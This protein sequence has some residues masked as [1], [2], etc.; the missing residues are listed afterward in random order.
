MTIP[1]KIEELIA[2]TRAPNGQRGDFLPVAA[3]IGP[4]GL[5]WL[6]EQVRQR[7]AGGDRSA[8]RTEVIREAIETKAVFDRL[9]EISAV[10]MTKMT[11]EMVYEIER[12]WKFLGICQLQFVQAAE[13]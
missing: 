5:D 11:A 13:P 7:K 1:T 4:W 3:R 2:E 8:R 9:R 6:E 12:L 10:P